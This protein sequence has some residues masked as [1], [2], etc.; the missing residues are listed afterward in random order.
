M[1]VKSLLKKKKKRRGKAEQLLHWFVCVCV[2]VCVCVRACVH[3]ASYKTATLL[4]S[5][6][7]EG[8]LVCPAAVTMLKL[9][10]LMR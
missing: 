8:A 5:N 1:S 10:S 6:N 2:C 9:L 3:C 7:S 4:W